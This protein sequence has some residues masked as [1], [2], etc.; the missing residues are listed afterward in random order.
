MI[1]DDDDDGVQ[2]HSVRLLPRIDVR[3]TGDKITVLADGIAQSTA[4]LDA[5]I[6]I[7]T[8]VADRCPRH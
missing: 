1:L 4:E 3:V 5:M 6:D 8:L 7:A 2:R